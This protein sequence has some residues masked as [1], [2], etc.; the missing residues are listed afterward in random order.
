VKTRNETHKTIILVKNSSAIASLLQ[1]AKIKVANVFLRNF[2]WEM[3]HNKGFARH[4]LQRDLE[5]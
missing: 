1:R 4:L 5:G 3:H 2:L